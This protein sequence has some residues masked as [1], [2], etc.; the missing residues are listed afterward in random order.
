M[1]NKKTYLLK[2][3]INQ[4]IYKKFINKISDCKYFY[5]IHSNII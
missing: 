4:F 3:K 1:I 5:K 2:K